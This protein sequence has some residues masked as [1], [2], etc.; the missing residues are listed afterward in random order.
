MSESATWAFRSRRIGVSSVKGLAVRLAGIGL[1]F[2]TTL[3]LAPLLGA[4]R[5]GAFTAVLT[6]CSLLATV[7]T[8]GTDRLAPKTI[9]ACPPDDDDAIA[10]EI[11]VTHQ[12][13]LRGMIAGVAL[14]A[15]TWWLLKVTGWFP[16]AAPVVACAIVV[17]PITM[18][19]TVRQW[20][21]LPLVGTA[22]S[23]V[24]EQ[25]L[26]PCLLLSLIS[27][28]EMVVDLNVVVAVW[29]ASGMV[30]WYAGTRTRPLRSVFRNAI[31]RRCRP[32]RVRERIRDGLPFLSAG[33]GTV[34]MNRSVPLVVAALLGF[35][36]AA[37]LAVAAQLA[38]LVAM[39]LGIINL[40]TM[41]R[42]AHFNAV[43]DRASVERV[44]RTGATIC[45]GL[46]VPVAVAVVLCSDTAIR[47]LGREFESC[48]TLVC[49]LV[50]APLANAFCGPNGSAMQMLGLERTYARILLAADVVQIAL[51]SAACLSG[52]LIAAAAAMV[53]VRIG[54]NVTLVWL[55]RRYYGIIPLPYLFRRPDRPTVPAS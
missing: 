51:V 27:L 3:M 49:V 28:T 24:P 18:L 6:A 26:L 33:L 39:P 15:G 55:L 36:D 40:T 31:S 22:A 1:A 38:A 17:L 16:A 20:T 23:I 13:A 54:W 2:A 11:S 42:C 32:E 7:L 34:M 12:V 52:N 44:L 29:A 47:L 53:A 19:L 48:S 37:Q 14:L 50:L 5:F 35:A 4:E 41:P 46:A 10:A 21:A 45:A 30:A 25:V 43:G 9:A 8:A